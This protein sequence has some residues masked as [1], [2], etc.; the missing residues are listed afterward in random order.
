MQD[1]TQDLLRQRTRRAVVA[2]AFY[3]L[4][5]A[6]TIALTIVLAALVPRPFG[7]WHWWYWLVLGGLAETFIV[8]TS[9]TDERTSDGVVAALLR[10][11]YDPGT[12]RNKAYRDRVQQA[13]RYQEGIARYVAAMPS[14]V[15]REY[16][17]QHTSGIADW[18]GNIYTI[19]ARLDRFERDEILRRDLQEIPTDTAR[20][21]AALAHEQDLQVK[22]QIQA[23]LLAKRAQEDNL[24]ALQNQMEQAQFRL[25]ETLSSLGTAYSQFQMISAK[26]LGDASAKQLT[27]NI[28]SQV[29]GLQDVITSMDKVY[30]KT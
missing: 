27:A 9:V 19:A 10:E 2:H 24:K 1:R 26:E 5:S 17:L 30:G 16:L 7:W 12:I 4:E 28:Q 21:R 20:L 25:E 11:H 13:L 22:Q 23:T 29:T 18:I 8:L 14:G 3:R 15:L 6:L